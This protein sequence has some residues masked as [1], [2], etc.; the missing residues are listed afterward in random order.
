MKKLITLLLALAMVFA[1]GS[2]A[3]ADDV[4]WADYQ[5]YLVEKAGA[6]AP[7]LDEF[8][9]QVEA[10]GS[11]EDLDLTTAPWDQMF[12][13]IGL[14]TWEEF[15]NGEVKEPAVMGGPDAS[16]SGE[17]SGE[18][19]LASFVY[20]GE[21]ANIQFTT[22]FQETATGGELVTFFK[23]T[24]EQITGG[25]IT[26]DVYY[27]GT[28]AQDPE[29]LDIVSTGAMNMTALGHNPHA[30]KL[31]LLTGVPDFAPDNVQN[32][33]DYF[34]YLL[35]GNPDSAAALEAEATANN[36]KFLGALAG[37]ANAF[38]A[39]FDFNNLTELLATSR[40]FG[41][42]EMTKFQ[43]LGFTSVE[44]VFPWD[45]YTAF[46]TGQIDA[47]Q[48]AS[49]SMLQD[50]VAEVTTTWMY[51][52]TYTAGNFMTVN[53]D[54]WNGLSAEQQEAIQLAVDATAAHSVE[55]YVTALETEAQTLT[56]MGIKI[57]EMTPEEFDQWWSVIMESKK[58]DTMTKAAD[59]GITAEA[60]TVLQAAADFT[61]YDIAF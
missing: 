20:T 36:V 31:P 25:A 4:T 2:A 42:M 44:A 59:A 14:S 5:A 38:V 29:Q 12:T 40:A 9:A 60:Q 8:K 35:K 26:V 43:T 37:G 52:N 16:A 48:M 45:L 30:D 7:S 27:G 54:W 58:D 53:L 32:A 56:D 6:N 23:D 34:N 41:N 19:D 11:W 15:Q 10:I 61:G 17:P 13:T 51:D 18:I 33:L 21:P 28:V 50:G 55:V 1:L 22:T 3:L 46:S 47:T 24:L 49:T 57:A 39:N